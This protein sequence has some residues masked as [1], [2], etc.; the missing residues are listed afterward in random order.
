MPEKLKT[1]SLRLGCVIGVPLACFIILAI[2]QLSVGAKGGMQGATGEIIQPKAKAAEGFVALITGNWN[3]HLEP[4]GCTDK[5]RGGIDRRT[6]VINQITED[7]E[8]RLLLDAGPLIDHIDRQD[9]LKFETF[10]YSMK[11]LNYDAICLTPYELVLLREKIALP[12][13]LHS[14]IVCT[15]MPE[16]N[17][18]DYHT[19]PYLKKTLDHEGRTLETLTFGLTWAVGVNSEIHQQKLNLLDPIGSLYDELNNLE[20]DPE[21]PSTDRLII[22]LLNLDDDDL[23]RAVT[24]I[25]AVDIMIMKGA[26]DKPELCP[27][28]GNGQLIFTT[29]QMG[30]YIARV[31][32]P[33]DKAPQYQNLTFS[34]VEIDSRFPRDDEIVNIID[35]YQFRLRFENLIEKMPRRPLE[36]GLFFV[37]N[38][39]CEECHEDIY[40]NWKKFSHYKA[41]DTLEEVGR[42]FNPECVACHTVGMHYET[43]Y[44]SMEKTPDLGNVGCEMCHGPGSHHLVYPEEEYREVFTRCETCH[45]HENSPMFEPQREEYFQKINHWQGKRKYWE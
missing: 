27:I 31:D 25:K 14:P 23:A 3:S 24:G 45:D 1:C 37:G 42:D 12:R 17:R 7:P 35:E 18:A 4:C 39:Q 28:N 30:K 9:Q 40:A 8:R 10:L 6:K 29:G 22:V 43:G 34:P 41:M 33:F 11:R 21:T 2:N 20:I 36:D 32:V 19:R 44:V 38:S 15:N 16:E 5:Q 26:A 13:E